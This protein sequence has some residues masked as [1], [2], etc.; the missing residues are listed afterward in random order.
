MDHKLQIG[1]LPPLDQL[2]ADK[3]LQAVPVVTAINV[4][5]TK[6]DKGGYRFRVPKIAPR[7]PANAPDG[8]KRDVLKEMAATGKSEKVVFEPDQVRYFKAVP[9][10]SECL[11]CHGEPKGAPDPTG[12][13]KE[14]WR[15]GEMHGAFEVINSLAFTQ[16]AVRS[17]KWSVALLTT[18]SLAVILTVV[19]LLVQQNLL[20]PLGN[21]KR[22]IGLVSS[23]DLTMTEETAAEDELG[24]I[25]NQIRRMRSNLRDLVTKIVQAGSTLSL[26]STELSTI[27]GDLSKGAENT[28]GRSHSVAVAAEEMSAN[29]NSVAAAME[30]ATT[31]MEFMTTSVEAVKGNIDSISTN[32]EN[33]RRVT[34]EAVSRAQSASQRVNLTNITQASTGIKAV[35]QNVPQSSALSGEIARDIAGRMLAICSAFFLFVMPPIPVHCSASLQ[36]STNRCGQVAP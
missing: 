26:S 13:T 29:M 35:N 22:L 19:W 7:N 3:I 16:A 1:M 12:G 27:S 20:K 2:P 25:I 23:G 11:Y 24:Q 31:N 4:A 30:Q 6:A 10:S 36:G 9:L 28:S 15:A 17:A 14:G 34:G 21:A 5:A 18:V 32:T 33:A 8:V